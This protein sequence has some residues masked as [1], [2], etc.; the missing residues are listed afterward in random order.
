MLPKAHR[1]PLRFHRTQ[2]ETTA[3]RFHSPLFT[4]AVSPADSS[5]S[6]IRFAI[7]VSKKIS[8]KAVDRN[9]VRRQISA[10]IAALLPHLRPGF[11]VIVYPKI[12][13]LTADRQSLVNQLT[14]QFKAARL[15]E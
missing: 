5:S 3:T 12:A 7:I 11:H 2:T 4:L 6:P 8:N 1:L 9:H 15:Y 14:T 13:I 10:A